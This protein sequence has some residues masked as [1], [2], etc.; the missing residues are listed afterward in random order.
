MMTKPPPSEGWRILLNRKRLRSARLSHKWPFWKIHAVAE[1]STSSVQ[2]DDFCAAGLAV[3]VGV[4]LGQR[5]RPRNQLVDRREGAAAVVVVADRRNGAAAVVVN[6][7]VAAT[8][9]REVW[10]QR[11]AQIPEG[12]HVR[13][14]RVVGGSRARQPSKRCR[15]RLGNRL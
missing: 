8:S 7:D 11:C 13:G 6:D 4:T 5:P 9:R 14:A 3:V 15:S 12:A 10:G 1:Y 2:P